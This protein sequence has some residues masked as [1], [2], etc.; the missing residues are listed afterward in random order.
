MGAKRKKNDIKNIFKKSLKVF[1]SAYQYV[2]RVIA[3]EAGLIRV[4]GL[5]AVSYGERVLSSRGVSG[6]VI[7]IEAKNVTILLLNSSSVQAGERL[8]ST[9][10]I[11]ALPVG[12]DL[13]GRIISPLGETLDGQRKLSNLKHMAIESKAPNFI[14]RQPVTIPLLTGWKVVDTL[15]P[16]GR[17]QRQLILGDRK[18][19]KTSVCIGIIVTQRYVRPA[20]ICVYVGI[21]KRTKDMSDMWS[22]LTKKDCM[23]HT[24]IVTTTTMDTAGL[25][26]I[27]PFAGCTAAEYFRD[28]GGHAVVI[29]DDLSQHADIYRQMALLLRRPPGREAYPG[30]VFYLHARLL[31]RSCALSIREGNGS[32]TGFPVVETV[33]KDVSAYIVTNLISITDGQ[34]Y[35]DKDVIKTGRLPPINLFLSVSRIG[36]SVQVKQFHGLVGKLKKMIHS[37]LEVADYENYGTSVDEETFGLIQRGKS[38]MR[39]LTQPK[40]NFTIMWEL[41]VILYAVVEGFADAVISDWF[42]LYELELLVWF[43]CLMFLEDWNWNVKNKKESEKGV[44]Y[45]IYDLSIFNSGYISG[46]FGDINKYFY[47]LIHEFSKGFNKRIEFI[48]KKTEHIDD[49]FRYYRLLKHSLSD[50][51]NL[52]FFDEGGSIAGFLGVIYSYD[53]LIYIN[54]SFL[55]V[56]CYVADFLKEYSIYSFGLKSLDLIN[57]SNMFGYLLNNDINW[58]IFGL[59]WGKLKRFVKNVISVFTYLWNSEY[60]ST[61]LIWLRDFMNYGG[62]V[63]WRIRY[64]LKGTVSL[65]K[66][67]VDDIRIKF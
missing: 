18:T 66:I 52:G 53:I 43:C 22:L 36:A 23:G 65:S 19:G 64:N 9:L 32:L 44:I 6:L 54:P 48:N 33:D 5:R 67:L 62:I 21:G 45:D 56:G 34:L 3:V 49:Y 47:T 30:D 15:F 8:L 12:M 1:R 16:I 41:F 24:I 28:N 10:R 61:G 20:V 2:G 63:T 4:S 17:G 59:N 13:L 58:K 27:A 11:L 35:L 60:I 26:Y 7:G 39:L 51:F 57:F 37:Y 31:E 55:Q 38:L 29:Y 40:Y 42:S 46:I 50:A 14:E 25:Q